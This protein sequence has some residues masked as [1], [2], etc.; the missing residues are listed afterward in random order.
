MLSKEM[1]R[2]Y[3]LVLHGPGMGD[4]FKFIF[5]INLRDLLL[6]CLLVENGVKP[7]KERSEELEVLLSDEVVAELMA[8]VPEMLK[9]GGP[10]LLDFYDLL[11]GHK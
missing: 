5:P 7:V 11:K 9:K 2:T 4:A 6:I 3:D 8:L 10:K 1:E